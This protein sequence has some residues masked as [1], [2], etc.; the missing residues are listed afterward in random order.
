MRAVVVDKKPVRFAM[1]R[2]L[3]SR[4]PQQA[5]SSGPLTLRDIDS[6]PLPGPDWVQASPVLAGICGSDLALVSMSSSR[7]FEPLTS[8]PFVPGHE[9]VASVGEE[10]PL[11]V[12]EPA[13]TCV[14][15]GLPL[16]KACQQG[17]TQLCESLGIGTIDPGIQL[18]YCSSTGG[19]W[20][21]QFIAHTSQLH[22]IPK[23]ISH[24]DAVMVEPLACA[25]HAALTPPRLEGDLAIIGGGTVGL[26]ILAASRALGN[27]SSI[28]HAV[29]YPIQKD[30]SQQLGADTALADDSLFARARRLHGSTR[31]GSY[32][33]S[34][35]DTVIDAVG[36]TSSLEQAMRIVRPGGQVVVAGM[37]HRQSLDLAPLWHR[38]VTLTGT[39]AY[40]T[41]TIPSELA[42]SLGL[43][44]AA[45]GR[46]TTVRTFALALALAPQ[47][48]LGRLVTHRYALAD[49]TTA[50]AKAQ[51][52]GRED[53][54]KVVF[55]LRMR[56][57]RH[58]S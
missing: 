23:D 25:L 51:S 43:S 5:I 56:K 30:F 46:T 41:E 33:G 12:I 17:D 49:Y 26:S 54:V 32:L 16:C 3:G 19:G 20:A 40:G 36:S 28:V 58:D 2:L 47:L 11:V 9:I 52:G 45:S 18:G 13:L 1:A 21:Q 24:A 8:F 27:Y 14:V 37:P 6:L 22:Q 29:R 31:I 35:F 15:R 44:G 10:A 57:V 38:E 50:I 53:A 39:Y 4:L 55:D 48:G 34:G 7:Y 42:L